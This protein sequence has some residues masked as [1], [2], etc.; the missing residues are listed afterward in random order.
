MIALDTSAI[1]AI[2]CREPESDRYNALIATKEALVGTPTLLEARMVLERKIP[3]F[4]DAFLTGFL[5]NAAVHPLA[6]TLEMVT[7]A[8]DAFRRYGKGRGHPAQLNFGDCLAYAVAKAEQVPLLY[9]GT[10][11]A[12]TDIAAAAP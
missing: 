10:D 8:T 5:G 1:V 12:S 4:A 6:F 9:K 7:A 2:A 11:F 3:G